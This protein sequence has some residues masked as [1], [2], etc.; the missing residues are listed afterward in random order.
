MNPTTRHGDWCHHGE[1]PTQTAQVPTFLP[2]H[3][4][5][6]PQTR[7][8]CLLKKVTIVTKW[9]ETRSLVLHLVGW[10]GKELVGWEKWTA[11]GKLGGIWD[12]E[13]W[14]A[15]GKLGGIWYREEWSASEKL[16]GIWD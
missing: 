15:S 7:L 6:I 10:Q 5:A 3:G 14:R 2:S 9:S 11:S 12:R 4:V 8:S 1:S 13:E 16:G